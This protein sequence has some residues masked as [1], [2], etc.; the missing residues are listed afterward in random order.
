MT[1]RA[2]SVATLPP[3]LGSR[4]SAENDA[5]DAPSGVV[6]AVEREAAFAFH[7]AKNKL[8]SM[9]LNLAYLHALA[10]DGRLEAHV[11]ETL[12]DLVSANDALEGLIQE[13][14][15]ASRGKARAS[16][17]TPISLSDLAVTAAGNGRR[18]AQSKWISVVVKG[19]V[20]ASVW[21]D[22]SELLRLL[23]NLVDNAVRYSPAHGTIEIGFEVE[24]DLARLWVSDQGPG[25]PA[26]HVATIFDEYYTTEE[27]RAARGA[28]AGLGL[29]YCL[30][31]AQGHGG[32]IHVLKNSDGGATFCVE[33]PTKRGA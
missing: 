7:D 15:L 1:H 20:D 8:A 3:K 30:R 10:K 5:H 9:R 11:A 4:P 24:G 16:S 22:R 18:S 31:V 25:V 26:D 28:S 12:D 14:L 6:L 27:G 17:R 19:T 33:L 23:D 21:G 13:A 32:Q 29:T 2:V